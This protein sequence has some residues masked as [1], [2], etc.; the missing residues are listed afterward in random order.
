MAQE[1][2]EKTKSPET[3]T[4]AQG[5]ADEASSLNPVFLDRRGP[6]PGDLGSHE[7]V[8]QAA[9]AGA[10]D[11]QNLPLCPCRQCLQPLPEIITCPKLP[12]RPASE[13]SG[14]G[15]VTPLV[16]H[17]VPLEGESCAFPLPTVASLPASPSR[18]P[19]SDPRG[20]PP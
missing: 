17:S 19:P 6:A 10:C 4:G 7:D 20:R 5:R 9:D 15:F 18:T 12:S 16:S 1:A 13:G 3:R 2:E 8:V 11:P 14:M